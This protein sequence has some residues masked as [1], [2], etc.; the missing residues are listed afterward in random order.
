MD[1]FWA[2]I[3]I[4]Y[5]RVNTPNPF[6]ESGSRKRFYVSGMRTID[7]PHKIALV[8]V[9]FSKKMHPVL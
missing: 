4:F 8:W 5:F 1:A 2:K 7:F 9:I 3:G 6:P